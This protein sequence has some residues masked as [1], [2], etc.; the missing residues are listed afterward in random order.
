MLIE[1]LRA[2]Q[3]KIPCLNGRKWMTVSAS[4]ITMSSGLICSVLHQ[5]NSRNVY[6]IEY[7]S[8]FSEFIIGLGL[9]LLLEMLVVFF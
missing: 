6:H 7:S 5:W 1:N 2:Y 8:D 9:Y 3:T 4:K